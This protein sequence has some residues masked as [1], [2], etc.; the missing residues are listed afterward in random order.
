MNRWLEEWEATLPLF[1]GICIGV[2]VL[3]IAIGSFIADVFA[4][5]GTYAA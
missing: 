2:V 5:F 1:I 3:V 4:R